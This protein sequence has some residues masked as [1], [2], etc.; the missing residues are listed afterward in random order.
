MLLFDELPNNLECEVKTRY[1]ALTAPCTISM[2]EDGTVK[3]TMKEK[4]KSV[5]PGQSAVFYID[6]VVVGGGKIIS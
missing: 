5:T 1:S 6:D 3:V 2:Q 4:A